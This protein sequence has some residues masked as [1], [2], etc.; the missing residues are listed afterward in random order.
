MEITSHTPSGYITI[1]TLYGTFAVK[2]EKT[3]EA[4]EKWNKAIF[5]ALKCNSLITFVGDQKKVFV[6]P[7]E[8]KKEEELFEKA[9]KIV[10][11][12]I[13]NLDSIGEEIIAISK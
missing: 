9:R 8:G 4:Y 5:D 2:A 10:C 6:G 13:W 12:A 1:K 11:D 7:T 3:H